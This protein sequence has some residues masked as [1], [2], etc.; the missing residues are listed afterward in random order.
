MTDNA[1]THRSIPQGWLR[2][3][4]S[5]LALLNGLLNV[6][7]LLSIPSAIQGVHDAGARLKS[8]PKPFGRVVPPEARERLQRPWP[9]WLGLEL[10]GLANTL[11]LLLTV[12]LLRSLWSSVNE[13][14]QNHPELD[15]YQ[16]LKP[17]NVAA[18]VFA[19]LIAWFTLDNF[20]GSATQ[21]RSPGSGVPL[22]EL[23]LLA[24]FSWLPCWILNARRPLNSPSSLI[25]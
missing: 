11:E 4:L 1:A 2:L 12:S 17:Y 9:V 24:L 21:H 5:I 20:W 8:D 3:S 10:L 13:E 23:S 7:M 15:R 18:L 25:G 19:F 16:R 22:I 14:R 6:G